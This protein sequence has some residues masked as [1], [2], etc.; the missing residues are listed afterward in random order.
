MKRQI[1]VNPLDMKAHEVPTFSHEE[2]ERTPKIQLKI[3][4]RNF[5]KE[6]KNFKFTKRII[7]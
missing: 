4:I 7:L 1:E 5:K 3:V 2:F 6:N